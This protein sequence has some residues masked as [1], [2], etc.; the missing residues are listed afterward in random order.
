MKTIKT[1]IPGTPEEMTIM[2][3]FITFS[4]FYETCIAE[5]SHCVILLTL[6]EVNMAIRFILRDNSD[7]DFEDSDNEDHLSEQSHQSDADAAQPQ[8]NLDQVQAPAQKNS[9]L[10]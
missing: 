9:R 1:F 5:K 6:L 3:P 10:R 8:D 4:H 7:S 2:I